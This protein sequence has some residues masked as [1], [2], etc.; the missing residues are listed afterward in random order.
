MIDLHALRGL[1][2]LRRGRRDEFLAILAGVEDQ[3][4]VDFCLKHQVAGYCH[5]LLESLELPESF[6]TEI[7]WQLRAAYLRQ[8]SRN[9]KLLRELHKLAE[10]FEAAGEEFLLLKGF[11][12]AEGFYGNS[13]SRA[14]N[15]LDLLVRRSRIE[16]SQRLLEQA[17]YG[18]ITDASVPTRLLLAFVHHLEL[19]KGDVPV[20]LHHE[21]RTHPS[22]GIGESDLWQGRARVEIGGRSLSVLSDEH[23]LLMAI[24]TIHGDIGLGTITLRPLVDLHV[25]LERL[26]DETDWTAFFGRREAERTA[27]L[28]INVLALFLTVFECEDQFPAL[29]RS[30]EKRIARLAITGE[31]EEY[32]QLLGEATLDRKKRWA[33]ECYEYPLWRA[34][35][36]WLASLP[37]Q[38]V[39]SPKNFL[40]DLGGRLSGRL[41]SSPAASEKESTSVSREATFGLK[42]SG[43]QVA[44][45][46]FGSLT[47]HFFTSRGL[48]REIVEELFRIEMKE[49]IADT[50]TPQAN[51]YIF[52]IDRDPVR[53]HAPKP[54]S[55]TLVRR[56]LSGEIEI[57]HRCTS[58]MVFTRRRPMEIFLSVRSA[59]ANDDHVLHSV[60]IAFYKM[61]WVLGRV[62]LHAAA[63]E[64]GGAAHVF[65]GDRGAGKTTLSLKLGLAGGVVLGEDH[66]M[67]R[68][69]DDGFVVSGCD[70]NMRLTDK[71]ERFFFQEEFSEPRQDYAGVF[72]KEV[73]AAQLLDSQP[74][75]D[76]RVGKLFFSRVGRRFSIDPVPRA[77]ALVR[78]LDGIRDRHRFAGRQDM[79]EF[80][81]FFADFV[82]GTDCFDLT[83]SQDLDDLD[84]LVSF[85]GCE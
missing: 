3:R 7:T 32:L 1:V 82:E 25:I 42:V 24:L 66:I 69:S 85:L 30:L 79:A 55:K 63:V 2:A 48:Y 59:G 16:S 9:E 70:P 61:L 78:L 50:A 21:I 84:Q 5:T 6:S 8:W 13:D 31:R 34:V 76:A 47:T 20:D 68:Q 29:T 75:R 43:L 54:M 83:L 33:F 12:L 53:G 44:V 37:V 80:L 81:D 35:G 46:R 41:V 4:F 52:D 57:H 49:V 19:E 22:L 65:V 18:L 26:G 51:V 27:R 62:Q 23:V 40:D 10:K 38:L 77:R 73:Q 11:H 39:A 36:W 17:G 15:D 58:L 45:G 71:T 60:M 72:K 74:Y 28:C 64:V 67:V 14:I 56:P